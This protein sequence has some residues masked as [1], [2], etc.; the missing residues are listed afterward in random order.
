M[1]KVIRSS[2]KVVLKIAR[3]AR[4][5]SSHGNHSRAIR[6]RRL[7]AT[8]GDNRRQSAIRRAKARAFDRVSFSPDTG[9]SFSE[10]RKGS[11]SSRV[12]E[13]ARKSRGFVAGTEI[14]SRRAHRKEPSDSTTISLISLFIG[15]GFL[16]FAIRHAADRET[17]RARWLVC[18][19]RASRGETFSV[20]RGAAFASPPNYDFRDSL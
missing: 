15:R 8:I 20:I 2:W 14:S 18:T 19:T 12:E 3:S 9:R 7:P 4:R 11:I 6:E 5:R 1:V 13:T 10:P 17:R 16:P